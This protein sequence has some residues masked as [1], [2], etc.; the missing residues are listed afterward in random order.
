MSQ[1]Q[2]AKRWRFLAQH[3]LDTMEGLPLHEWLARSLLRFGSIERALDHVIDFHENCE[4]HIAGSAE[5]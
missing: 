1:D 5:G 4:R 2:D 3:W